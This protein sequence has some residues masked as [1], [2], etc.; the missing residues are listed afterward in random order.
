M[1]KKW[2]S[3]GSWPF[4]CWTCSK[5]WRWPWMYPLI[6]DSRACQTKF[7]QERESLPWTLY[8]SI[9]GSNLPTKHL[10][11]NLR[12][13][14]SYIMYEPF[15]VWVIQKGYKK[16]YVW[17][18]IDPTRINRHIM[19]SNEQK[20]KIFTVFQCMLDPIPHSIRG[21]N[22]VSRPRRSIGVNLNLSLP[23]TL[24]QQDRHFPFDRSAE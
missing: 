19:T 22:E 10:N 5:V 6:R 17:P 9:R 7:I 14:R 2:R 16:L 15:T 24:G 21:W 13:K 4:G 1:V 12:H 8:F 11:M 23:H 20:I 3:L 18:I